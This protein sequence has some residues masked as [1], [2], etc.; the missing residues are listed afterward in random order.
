VELLADFPALES[1]LTEARGPAIYVC[2]GESD[3]D[4]MAAAEVLGRLGRLQLTAGPGGFAEYLAQ[5]L[6]LPSGLMLRPP[7]AS[8]VLTV[9]GSLNE[10]SLAQVRRAEENGCSVIRLAPEQVLEED[11]LHSRE[12]EVLIQNITNSIKVNRHVLL[13]SVSSIAELPLYLDYAKARGLNEHEAHRLV[14]AQTGEIVRRAIGESGAEG[15]IIFGGDTA[16]G[17]LQDSI[18]RPAGEVLPGI[19]ISR[20]NL[21]GRELCL[22]TKAGGFGPID[23][24]SAV[25]E[26]IGLSQDAERESC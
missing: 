9:C 17:I 15:L 25:R 16:K 3:E 10:A 2:D 22:V 13:R 26:A 6:D 14:A 19:P 4:L 7:A 5:V 8:T 24:L 11:F 1:A 12:A 21:N 20:V 18:I 23:V